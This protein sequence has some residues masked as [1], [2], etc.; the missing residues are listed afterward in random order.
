MLAWLSSSLLEFDE[1]SSSLFVNSETA[2]QCESPSPAW[3]GSDLH[4]NLIHER[5]FSAFFG[6]GTGIL[7]YGRFM[8]AIS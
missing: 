1:K 5:A 7:N 4:F 6:G 2:W 8:A 3:V